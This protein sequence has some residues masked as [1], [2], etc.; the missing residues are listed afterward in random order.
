V[1]V[2]RT[3]RARLASDHLP[4]IVDLEIRAPESRPEADGTRNAS[5]L[6]EG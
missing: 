1:Q 5:C 6:V 4:M 2:P 3:P